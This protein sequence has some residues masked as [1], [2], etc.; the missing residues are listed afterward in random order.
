MD[1]EPT[2][3]LINKIV[4]H[5]SLLP[6]IQQQLLSRVFVKR[7]QKDHYLS[8]QE[9]DHFY[10]H[11][12]ILKKENQQNGDI[13]HFILEGDFGVFPSDY[14]HYSLVSIEPCVL[15]VIRAGDIDN[16]LSRHKQLISP[17]RELLFDWARKRQQRIEFMLLPAAERKAVLL[18]R[19]G[20]SYNRIQNKDLANYLHMNVSYFSQL[21]L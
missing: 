20:K 11:S 2:A 6:E 18:E 4:Q 9:R 16:L 15:F 3:K 10:L 19:L 17:Y 21:Q 13:A 1:R 14:G 5:V 8:L 7:I 12:G